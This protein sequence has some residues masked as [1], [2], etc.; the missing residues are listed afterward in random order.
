M[1]SSTAPVPDPGRVPN[2]W[3]AYDTDEVAVWESDLPLGL[4]GEELLAW[5]DAVL[6]AGERY[7]VM[8]VLEAPEWDY[9]RDRDGPVRQWLRRHGDRIEAMPPY[10][11]GFLLGR[12][13]AYTVAALLAY[14]GPEGIGQT[15]VSDVA[16][17]AVSVGLP[18]P[19]AKYP[20][21]SVETMWED[22]SIAVSVGTAIDIWFAWNKAWHRTE[23][24][25]IDNRVLARLNG[26]RLNGFLADVRAACQA[27][28]GTW[29]W[30]TD[31]TARGYREVDEAGF[32]LLD[33][34]T[35]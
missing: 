17:F 33:Q 14:A 24:G 7:S 28:G 12:I 26:P 9:R 20:P 16:N 23:P 8:R 1:H 6:S 34:A 13:Q 4:S 35:E 27:L 10:P 29:T 15:W 18:W 32:V 5:Q 3:N 31:A 21:L 30:D 2:N 19:G 11:S 22:D 25:P